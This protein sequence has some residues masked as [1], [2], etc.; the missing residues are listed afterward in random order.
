MAG[1]LTIYA[2]FLLNSTPIKPSPNNQVKGHLKRKYMKKYA[3]LLV[4]SAFLM[5]ASA[6]QPKKVERQNTHQQHQGKQK[7][8]KNGQYFK[9]LNLSETQKQAMKANREDFQ[10]KDNALKNQPGITL[11][12]YQAGKARLE[13]E[14]K[15]KM[16]S[17]LTTE[18]K[19]QISQRERDNKA[20]MEQRQ[21]VKM[22]RM[23]KELSLTSDQVSKINSQRELTNQQMMALKNNETLTQEQK[24]TE[25]QRIKM[26][27]KEKRDAILTQEQLQKWQNQKQ[28]RDSRK[29]R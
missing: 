12:D 10:Q 14:R 16:Q 26:E 18:Q 9:G 29:K 27:S 23:T 13:K 11:N 3:V 22:D 7:M 19:D 20:K 24:R 4:L 17:I 6:Q 15:E 2:T 5:N 1:N 25:A 21:K 8:H 28:K